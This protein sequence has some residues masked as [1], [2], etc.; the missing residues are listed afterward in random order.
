MKII[1][2]VKGEIPSILKKSAELRSLRT[3]DPGFSSCFLGLVTWLCFSL[4]FLPRWFSTSP[5]RG[6]H[7]VRW[8]IQDLEDESCLLSGSQPGIQAGF[9]IAEVL[10]PPSKEATRQ[11]P[12][13]CTLGWQ[14][15][16]SVLRIF[17]SRT[18]PKHQI[19]GDFILFSVR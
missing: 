10:V 12:V 5:Q 15:R 7:R 8:E 13:D 3:P 11:K 17:R 6:R 2:P 9:Q 4:R 18:Q 19:N 16:P 14:T 1:L